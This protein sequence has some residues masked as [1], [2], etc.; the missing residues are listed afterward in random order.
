MGHQAEL[1]CIEGAWAENSFGSSMASPLEKSLAEA[2]W[3][4]SLELLQAVVADLHNVGIKDA[5]HTVGERT[6]QHISR[7]CDAHVLSFVQGIRLTDFPESEQWPED[8]KR[9]MDKL[10][11]VSSLCAL[12]VFQF[13]WS[14]F[15]SEIL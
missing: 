2:G 14:A 15:A 6:A 8:I 1:C 10:F 9:F 12:G 4:W 11:R 5:P 3:A 7:E 13:Q